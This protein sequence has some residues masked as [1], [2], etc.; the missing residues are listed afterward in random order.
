MTVL[1]N[2]EI[3]TDSFYI[4]LCMGIFA[5]LVRSAYEILKEKKLVSP[6]NK[7]LFTIIFADMAL[8]WISWFKMCEI[9]P[10]PILLPG[11]I[12]LAGF[13][14]SFIGLMMFFIALFKLRTL[15][16]Y[17]GDLVTSG[18]FKYF[19][20]PIYLAFIFWLFGFALFSSAGLSLIIAI[21]FTMNILF[22]RNMEEKDLEK[23][24]P[25][26]KEYKT[27]TYF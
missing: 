9:D 12:Q 14:I 26:Y 10:M 25:E 11:F 17:K 15:E 3:I 20:H 24:Y 23:K 6:G 7:I 5:H 19:R 16:N 1:S 13:V 2:I 27:K 4:L 22:W 18:I 21:P 8:L